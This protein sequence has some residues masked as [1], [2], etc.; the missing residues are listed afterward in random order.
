MPVGSIARLF[1]KCNGKHGVDVKSTP[2]G[3]DIA[4]S[5]TDNKMYLHVVNLEYRK[6]V[7]ATFAVEGMAVAGGRV[8]EIAPDDLRQA[9]SQDEPNVFKPRAKVLP[10]GSVPTWNFRP[11]SVTAIELD[12][13]PT[14]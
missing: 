2:T 9:V 13:R 8:F 3:L 11:G 10:A 1:N 4:A 6:S 5:R 14:A 7:E 12:L